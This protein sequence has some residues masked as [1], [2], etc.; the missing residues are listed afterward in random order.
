M[1]HVTVVTSSA[2]ADSK[3]LGSMCLYFVV[4]YLGL[5]CVHAHVCV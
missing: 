5:H 4:Y 2:G 1:R 3:C